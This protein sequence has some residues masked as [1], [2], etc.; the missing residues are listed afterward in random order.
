MHQSLP[1]SEKAAGLKVASM[2]LGAG[3]GREHERT[4]FGTGILT[5]RKSNL[6]V[7]SASVTVKYILAAELIE[8]R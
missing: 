6:K 8:T 5:L 4:P 1:E 7:E 2:T 3:G